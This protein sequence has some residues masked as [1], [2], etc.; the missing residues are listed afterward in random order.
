MI[1][2]K[3][4]SLIPLSVFLLTTTSMAVGQTPLLRV[5]AATEVAHGWQVTL[6]NDYKSAVTAYA[7]TTSGGATKWADSIPGDLGLRPSLPPQSTASIFVPGNLASAP[8]VR[9]TAVIYADGATAGD[10]VV[11]AE[12]LHIRAFFLAEI[13]AAIARMQAVAADP[14]ATRSTLVAEFRQQAQANLPALHNGVA[15]PISDHV[16]QDIAETLADPA[17]RSLQ[18]AAGSL[19]ATL[20]RWRHQLEQSLPRLKLAAAVPSS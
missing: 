16:S 12:F 10:P 14:G 13:P 5:S 8:V 20:T 11:I 9:N 3:F 19:A 7:L 15:G 6:T 1:R 17:N 18:G 2:K 4:P